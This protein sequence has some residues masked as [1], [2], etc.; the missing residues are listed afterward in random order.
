M[1]HIG[2]L[3]CKLFGHKLITRYETPEDR[4]YGQITIARLNYCTRCGIKRE[5][6]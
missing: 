3:R 5:E 4:H 6:L 2:T 1:K